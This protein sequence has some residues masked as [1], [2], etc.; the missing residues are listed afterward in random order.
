MK[1]IKNEFPNPVLA[2]GRDDYIESCCFYTTFDEN[3]IAVDAD[4]ITFSICYTL[5]CSGLETMIKAGQAVAVVLI[6]S[7]AASYSKLFKFPSDSTE[8]NISISKYDVVSKMDIYGSIIAA[9]NIPKF[10]CEGEF[11]ELY[12][13]TSIF[14]IRKGDI[15]A[16]ED[17]RSIFV[18]D[19]ELE[20]PISSI[21]DISRNDDQE[22]DIAPNFYG[23][24]IE[25]F[26]KSELYDLYYKFKDFNNG[27]LRRYAAGVIVYPVLVE[28]IMYIT[29]YYQNEQQGDGT[30]LS[31]RRWFRAI[32]HK[33]NMKGVNL[34]TYQESPT[35]LANDL[36][37][38]I[39]LDALKSFKD[40][41]DSEINSGET[42]M[43]GGAD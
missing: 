34:Q 27:A 1:S 26:L 30:D 31:E 19:S 13:G 20:R 16:T 6:K 15:L 5:K 7:S 18:D 4:N 12:F 38:D 41:L 25:I 36:L 8:L 2:S 35:S 9:D 39:A 22:S 33:A 43:I 23:Q 42:Q 14:E 10:R 32:D 28:A 37:G 17:S 3:E 21:F 29:G 40:A 11:N 24:K